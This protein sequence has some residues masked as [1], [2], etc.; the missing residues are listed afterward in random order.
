[1]DANADP[2][3]EVETIKP[4][5]PD[6]QR[7]AIIVNNSGRRMQIINQSLTRILC[8]SY[9]VQEKQIIGLPAW[10]DT[11]KFDIDA[12]PD[13]EGAPNDKQWKRMI[14]KMLADRFKLTLHLDKKEMSVYALSVANSSVSAAFP[15]LLAA[16]MVRKRTG[17]CPI[18][19]VLPAR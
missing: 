6:D 15:A 5:K 16:T 13:G 14:Q 12:Q 7:R 11:D 17:D 3:F 19:L 18:A 2:S 10:A 1:M 9:G 4:S 8:F